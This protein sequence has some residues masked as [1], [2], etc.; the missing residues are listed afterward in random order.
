MIRRP[1]RS[2]HCISSAAS[3]VYKRQGLSANLASPCLRLLCSMLCIGCEKSIS[4][5][6]LW[7]STLYPR[8]L[9]KLTGSASGLFLTNSFSEELSMLMKLTATGGVS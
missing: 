3:D 5:S 8:L 9:S 4:S 6:T 7:F 1:P 2:T